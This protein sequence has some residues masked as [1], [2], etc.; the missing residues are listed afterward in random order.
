MPLL[1][2]LLGAA[3][4]TWRHK[5]LWPLGLII[6]APL[7]IQN[8]WQIF[9]S[10]LAAVAKP[11]DYFW[12]FQWSN[13]LATTGLTWKNLLT[14]IQTAPLGLI[15]ILAQFI[16]FITILFLF[17]WVVVNAQ[18]IIIYLFGNQKSP[19]PKIAPA[20]NYVSPLW[21][22]I[23]IL[24]VGFNLFKLIII[25]LLLGLIILASNNF[26]FALWWL[27]MISSTLIAMMLSFIIRFS[28]YEIILAKSSISLALKNSFTLFKKYLLEC[29]EFSLALNIINLGV[30]GFIYSIINSIIPPDQFNEIIIGILFFQKGWWL[31]ILSL[32]IMALVI[33]VFAVL[34]LWQSIAW[35]NWYNKIQNNQ[36]LV[37]SFIKQIVDK[38][39]S[40]IKK[41]SSSSL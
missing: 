7:V 14:T 17:A 13:S 31:F 16:L 5:T 21:L 2:I 19:A 15:T 39:K 37:R 35:L 27:V 29:F 12:F 10:L 8:E 4:A 1:N 30:L 3:K 40:K 11:Q 28:L 38:I 26:L 32:L 22:S 23:L 20:L 36:T 9:K 25:S 6:S 34:T 41:P 33:S 18:G 24:N